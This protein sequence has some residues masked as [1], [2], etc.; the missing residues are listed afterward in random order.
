M[1]CCGTGRT[2]PPA[3]HCHTKNPHTKNPHTKNPHTKNP[4]TKNPET[5]KWRRQTRATGR[6]WT[7]SRSS[8]G[9]RAPETETL[10]RKGLRRPGFTPAER[11][12]PNR[13][14]RCPDLGLRFGT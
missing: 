8:T 5:E 12:A 4:H 14:A 10:P 13:H 9:P 2:G 3:G 6:R 7:G 1:A 11:R